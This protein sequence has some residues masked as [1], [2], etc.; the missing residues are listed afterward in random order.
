MSK[1]FLALF[2]GAMAMAVASVDYV[3]ESRRAG[4]A[5]GQLG[6]MD[7]AQAL[8]QRI[9][10]AL[11]A[12]MGRGGPASDWR[13]TVKAPVVTSLAAIRTARG[14]LVSFDDALRTTERAGAPSGDLRFTPAE[15]PRISGGVCVTDGAF[16][17]CRV[18]E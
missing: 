12:E 14:E 13:E 6:G 11:G 2:L 18:A 8:G 17:R 15:S 1:L 10:T 16:K 3:N 7:Y 4:L 5:L 9:G